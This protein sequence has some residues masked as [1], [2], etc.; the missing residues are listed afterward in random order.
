LRSHRRF[1]EL[2][3]RAAALDLQARTV[4]LDNGGERLLGVQVDRKLPEPAPTRKEK[5]SMK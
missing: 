1:T 5:Q 3:N 4:F 2:V